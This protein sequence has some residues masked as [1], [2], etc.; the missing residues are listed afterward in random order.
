M[1]G[2]RK[3]E[4][5]MFALKQRHFQNDFDLIRLSHESVPSLNTDDINLKTNILGQEFSYPFYINAMTGGTKKATKV[6]EKLAKIALKYNIPFFIGSQSIALKD[7]SLERNY[8]DLRNKY[9]E[10]FFVANV[11]PNVTLV[12]AKRAIGMIKANALAIHVNSVQELAMAEGD[13]DFSKWLINIESV[14]SN[15]KIPVIVKEVGYGMTKDT[16]LKLKSVGVK[17]IDISGS[18]GTDFTEIEYRRQKKKDSIFS[19]FKI[20]TVESLL[21]N[22]EVNGVVL[23]ASGGVRSSL[24]IIKALAL[25]AKAVGLAHYFLKLTKYPDYIMYKEINTLIEELKKIMSLI[26]A[27][28]IEDINDSMI[29]IS[30]L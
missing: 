7:S 3:N 10:V 30:K 20:S 6:N 26:N 22:S 11:N 14:V 23:H 28:N 29:Y 27:Q 15:I 9:P 5:L 1:Q 18:G 17:Y 19:N 2:K 12:E 25:N 24:D 13:R 8:I 4:H 16:V 21:D